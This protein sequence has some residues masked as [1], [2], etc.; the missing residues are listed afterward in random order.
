MLQILIFK[1]SNKIYTSNIFGDSYIFKSRRNIT[2]LNNKHFK[3][4]IYV[5][6]CAYSVGSPFQMIVHRY[7][8]SIQ[9]CLVS[10]YS[11]YASSSYS[12]QVKVYHIVCI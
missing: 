9:N 12:Y 4:D 8:K 3:F 7:C 6:S 11:Q 10:V 5:S 1:H 2:A